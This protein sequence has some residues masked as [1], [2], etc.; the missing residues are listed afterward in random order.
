MR[1]SI[2]VP[3][4][5][6]SENILNHYRRCKKVISDLIEDGIIEDNY[7]YIIVDNSSTDETKK[8]SSDKM[9]DQNV[10]IIKN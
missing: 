1:L 10:S 5:N 2:V 7:E 9:N 8:S 4:Y 3:T 6:E